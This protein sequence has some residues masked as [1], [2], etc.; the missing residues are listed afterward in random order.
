MT[1][2]PFLE[3]ESRT[4]I[5]GGGEGGRRVGEDGLG[6][7]GGVGFRGVDFRTERMLILVFG[8][9]MYSC[10]MSLSTGTGTGISCSWN[11]STSGCLIFGGGGDGSRTGV[12]SLMVGGT[13]VYL[14]VSSFG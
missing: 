9:G 1:A 11:R 13:E 10:V 3:G 12:G 2:L 6:A 7:G 4:R 5:L 8:G 14:L